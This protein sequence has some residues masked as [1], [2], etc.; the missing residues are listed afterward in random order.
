MHIWWKHIFS[1][2]SF[3]GCPG[4]IMR[5]D[6]PMYAIFTCRKFYRGLAPAPSMIFSKKILFKS[7]P[8]WNGWKAL[9]ILMFMEDPLP[10]PLSQYKIISWGHWFR[11][12]MYNACVWNISNVFGTF[13]GESLKQTFREVH[14]GAPWDLTIFPCC[15]KPSLVIRE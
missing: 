6:N 2:C 14:M 15:F 5:D 11:L 1:V 10:P 4:S 12:K 8:S 13:F 9:K 7:Y 3:Q